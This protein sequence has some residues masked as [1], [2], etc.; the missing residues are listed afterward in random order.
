VADTLANSTTKTIGKSNWRWIGHR[1]GSGS[2]VREGREAIGGMDFG[3]ISKCVMLGRHLVVVD[4]IDIRVESCDTP[5][6]LNQWPISTQ[7][8]AN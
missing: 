8:P 6:H 3:G 4:I 2:E 5:I 7:H 1:I